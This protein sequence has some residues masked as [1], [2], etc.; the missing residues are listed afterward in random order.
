MLKSPRSVSSFDKFLTNGN[1]TGF[2]YVFCFAL[3]EKIYLL[4][5]LYKIHY[6]LRQNFIVRYSQRTRM[7]GFLV[8]SSVFEILASPP[9]LPYPV[10]SAPHVRYVAIASIVMT[11][12]YY[13][14]IPN[15][16]NHFHLYI[17]LSF[18]PLNTFVWPRIQGTCKLQLWIEFFPIHTLILREMY[19]LRHHMTSSSWHRYLHKYRILFLTSYS[20]SQRAVMWLHAFVWRQSI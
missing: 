15:K 20:N 6:F 12:N 1:I 10:L 9:T 16:S 17:C 19:L 2:V 18:T 11:Y 14:V 5:K 3:I 7:Y 4:F 8:L 13:K